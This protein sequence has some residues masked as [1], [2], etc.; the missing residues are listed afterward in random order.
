MHLS[1][2]SMNQQTHLLCQMLQR[3]AENR[4][5]AVVDD[6]EAIMDPGRG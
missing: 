4:N 3:M 1:I 6:F 5:I 2:F